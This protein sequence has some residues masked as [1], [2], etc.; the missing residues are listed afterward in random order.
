MTLTAPMAW[1]SSVSLSTSG[2]TCSLWGMVM[3]APRKSSPRSSSMASAKLDRPAGPIARSG[4]RCPGHRRQPAASHPRRSGRP[5][6]RSRRRDWSCS[7]PLKFREEARV[8]DGRAFG[9]VDRRRSAGDECRPRRRSSPAGDRPSVLVAAPTSGVGPVMVMSSP[10]TETRAPSAVSPAAMPAMRSDSL[11]RSSPAPRIVVWPRA[12][13]AARHRIGISSMAAAT[14]AGPRSIA[15]SSLD[16]TVRSASG[17]PD[18]AGRPRPPA[19]RTAALVDSGAHSDQDV[20]GGPAGRV[21][22][23]AAQGQLGIGMDRPGDEPEGGRRGICRDALVEGRK[24]RSAL[25]RPGHRSASRLVSPTR[26]G[27][28][29]RASAASAPCGPAW[30]P[31][32][33]T[34][35]RPS[36]RRPASRIADLT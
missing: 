18:L 34:V 22:T 31:A 19:S 26:A 15:R 20:D 23:Y 3:F 17:S 13:V 21:Y 11:L 33:R 29:R 35:V 28:R 5:G 30:Q 2:T 36:A 14:S 32:S 12:C 24:P 1:A 25:Q 4:R 7:Q 8:R 27:P 9:A 6:G 16:R 10:L